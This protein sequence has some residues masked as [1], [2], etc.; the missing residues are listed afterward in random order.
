MGK[1][2]VRQRQ[3]SWSSTPTGLA[4]RRRCGTYASVPNFAVTLPRRDAG[5]DTADVAQRESCEGVSDDRASSGV[6]PK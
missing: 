3:T 5:H 2:T 1:L 6:S 4:S